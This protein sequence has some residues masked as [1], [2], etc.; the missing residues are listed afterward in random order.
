MEN[1]TIELTYERATLG[2]RIAAFLVDAFLSL[3][4]SAIFLLLTFYLLS[5]SP[6]MKSIYQQRDDIQLNSHL[7]LKDDS[8]NIIQL[9]ESI[10][11]DTALTIKEK[12]KKY[13]DALTYF[14][15][16]DL[17]FN[18]NE[19]NEIYKNLKGN[20]K[21][22]DNNNL[23]NNDGIEIYDDSLHNDYYLSF[24]EDSYQKALS[25]MSW[26]NEYRNLNRQLLLIDT[27]SVLGTLL[28]PFLIFSYVI[29]LFNVR[30]RQT[31][32]M[33]ATKIAL[34]NVNGLSV[35]CWKFTLRFLFFYVIELWGSLLSFF[36]PFIVSLTMA[37]LSKAHQSLSDYITNTYM[38]SIDNKSIYKDV[39]EYKLAQQNT[40]KRSFIQNDIYT[41]EDKKKD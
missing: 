33:M 8:N 21:G 35:K 5:V 34:I 28:F 41:P 29:P 37:V 20:A 25:Y 18:E 11:K 38:V 39:F 19:G 27:F 26:N 13:D 1:E 10:S 16:S 7:Y 31:L 12:N 36:I 30:T 24:Y 40:T 14:F 32:G 2:R 23:F 22:D 17:F 6:F 3:L 4:T 15:D 9:K